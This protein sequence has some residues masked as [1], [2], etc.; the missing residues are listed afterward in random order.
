MATAVVICGYENQLT[1]AL[2][3]FIESL[4]EEIAKNFALKEEHYTIIVSGGNTGD[5][6]GKWRTEASLMYVIVNRMIAKKGL[7]KQK[8]GVV[9]E[10]S[11]YNTL[12]N[13][14]FS[15]QLL[16]NKIDEFD[17]IIIACNDAHLVKNVCACL[18]VFGTKTLSRK[19]VFYTFPLTERFR[20]NIKTYLKT[21]FE[22]FGYF[23]RPAGRLLEYWQWKIR[24]GRKTKI[25]FSAFCEKFTASG[26]LL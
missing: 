2:V 23:F 11:A 15:K 10:C 22:V 17:N 25:R 7:P 4:V 9:M 26:E 24:T 12:T 16:G 6:D 20:E 18:K 1:E 21:P 3:C 13:H 8:M 19:V 14:L 5:G